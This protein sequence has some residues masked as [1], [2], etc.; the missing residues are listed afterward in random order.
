MR[1]MGSVVPGAF[2]RYFISDS[3]ALILKSLFLQ[4]VNH[5]N[6]NLICKFKS[7]SALLT[8]C[9]QLLK[10]RRVYFSL[11]TGRFAKSTTG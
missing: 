7:F 10:V 2:Q 4:G 1:I 9:Q 8:V 6:L 3:V 5:K 11:F